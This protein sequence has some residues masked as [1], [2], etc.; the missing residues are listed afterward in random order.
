MNKNVEDPVCHMA[1]SATSFATEYEGIGYAFYSMQCKD[2][3]LANPHLYIGSPGR[4]AAQQGKKIVKQRS[5]VLS[6]P[7]DR[8]Q[9]DVIKCRHFW[10]KSLFCVEWSQ[11]NAGR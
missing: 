4:K 7:L 6:A 1:V 9:A 11:P 3:F 10:Q 2:R 5:M 8:G